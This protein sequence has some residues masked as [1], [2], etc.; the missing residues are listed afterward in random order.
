MTSFI[1]VLIKKG[2]PV[3][4]CLIDSGWLEV[5]TTN[6]LETYNDLHRKNQ[7]KKFCQFI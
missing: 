3:K 7:L 2:L 5:D 6:D 1:E 4:A